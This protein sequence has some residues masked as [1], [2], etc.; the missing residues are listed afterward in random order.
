MVLPGMLHLAIA[1]QP[2]RARQD[3]PRRRR[4][5]H[6]RPRAS[7]PSTP[8]ATSPTSRARIPCAWP[9]TPGHGQPRHP[10]D[11][12]RA[13]QP[14]RRGGR[15]HRRP[16]PDGRR[17][18]RSSWSTSTTT[19]CPSVLDMEEAVARTAPICARPH[20]VERELPLRLRRRRGRHGQ[21]HRPGVR[22]RR[23]RRQPPVRPAAADPGV[24]GAA[25]GR[26]PAAGR[27]LHD[28]VLD[29]GPAHPPG[30]AGAD[31]RHPRAQDA[32]D[33][34]RRRR[35]LRRQAAGHAGG[36]P[37]PAGGPAPRQAG[38][39]DR[40]P[41][42]V[43]DDRPPRP[44][45]DPV[46]R[47]RRRPRGQRQ[48]AALPASSPTW[49]P[50]CGC[51]PRE[52]RSSAPSCIVGD[53]QVPRLPVR[54]QRRLHQQG[55]RPTP[56]A[57]PAGPRRPSPSSGSWTSSPSSSA[58]TRSSCA[59]RTGSRPRSSPSPRPR[60]SSTTAATTRRRRSRRWSC[61]ATTSCA[62]SSGAAG[63]PTTPCSSASASPPSPRCAGWRPPG[64]SA[65]SP[66]ARVAG[67]T[68]P[69]GCCPPARSR[70]SPGRR[71]TGRGTRRRGASSSPTQLGV[72][73]EDVEVL[74]GDTAISPRGL[75]TYGSRSLVVG[76]AAVIKAAREGGR[77]G[78]QGRG[79]PAGGQRGRPG[80]QRRDVL[81]PRDARHRGDHPGDRAGA[82][83]RR[84]TSPRA[85]SPPS[86]RR[87]R[88]TR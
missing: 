6:S 28:V 56:T 69:S 31:H 48:G 9:V 78:P 84:T 13:G 57:A 53:L 65:R 38:Q 11:G 4:C 66:T 32:R 22:R 61:S 77:Q 41:Q 51:S 52:C 74:H 15:G 34:A 64:C 36:G 44:R 19:R 76:G 59:A 62:P 23:G 29:P 49:A 46:H 87:R 86:T 1:A 16:Q 79:P 12:G 14:R 50:T 33:R 88:S 72:P 80:L 82:R 8:A 35:R 43:A 73:F 40:D 85:W 42:R 27:Q 21:R 47:H 54:V 25:L 63:S 7:S 68:R 60:G 75:D 58:W 3:H 5:R 18:R 10:V 20:H 39:V 26:G 81:G 83:S 70:W 55:A 30:D 45:P 24:H 67:R 17:G 37:L 71:R 2:R